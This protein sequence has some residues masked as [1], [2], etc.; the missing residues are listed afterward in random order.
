MSDVII[1]GA[2][3]AG[4]SL[5]IALGRGGFEVE[6]YEQSTFPR[7]KPCGEGLLPAGVRVSRSGARG[8]VEASSSGA[9][10][11]TSLRII[12][13]LGAAMVVVVHGLGQK[14]F[15]STRAGARDPHPGRGE[16]PGVVSRRRSGTRA[17][18]G[19]EVEAS[20]ARRTGRCRDGSTPTPQ[21]TDSNA[22]RARR[23]GTANIP[24]RSGAPPLSDIEIF[25]RPGYELYVTPLP[26]DEVL[27][28]ALASQD[29]ATHALR[30]A[31][32][33]WRRG[34]PLLCQWLAG[35]TQ[36]SELMGRAPLVS[37]TGGKEPTGLIL[38]GDAAASVDPI[39][40]GGLSLALQVPSSCPAH[41]G[42]SRR[43]RLALR[44]FE[45]AR[46]RACRS[47]ASSGPASSRS[48]QDHDSWSSRGELSRLSKRDAIAHRARGKP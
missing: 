10:A 36:T 13:R 43:H 47:T 38:L 27:V 22:R 46:T 14:S 29:V 40:A 16:R 30:N 32:A 48:R 31:F 33:A 3:P 39:T 24:A 1:V 6:L 41:R 37:A 26:N 42:N 7:E 8:R 25:I 23:V 17:R 28:A 5:A 21:K 18:S 45:R 34:E 9:C 19:V 20:G 12:P 2:G 15:A 11:T 4:A 35:A 44:R